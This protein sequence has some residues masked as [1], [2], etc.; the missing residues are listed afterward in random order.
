MRN[1]DRRI[2]RV[3]IPAAIFATISIAHIL[4]PVTTSGDS[5]WS[6]PIVI[7][8]LTEGNVDINEYVSLREKWPACCVIQ[9]CDRDYSLSPWLPNCM[10]CARW[11]GGVLWSK[12]ESQR[13]VEA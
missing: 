9:V 8:I 2:S 1:M 4:S 12:K 6:V 13:I 11:R 5:R 7:S 10:K 3:L